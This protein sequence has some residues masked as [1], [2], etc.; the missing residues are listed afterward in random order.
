MENRPHETDAHSFARKDFAVIGF[1]TS[2][3]ILTVVLFFVPGFVVSF[4]GRWHQFFYWIPFIMGTPIFSI[5][6]PVYSMWKMDE[7]GWGTSRETENKKQSPEEIALVSANA[8]ET[9]LQI[10]ESLEDE[11][12]GD[13]RLLPETGPN[14]L[15]FSSRAMSPTPDAVALAALEY[16]RAAARLARLTGEVPAVSFEDQGDYSTGADSV[17]GM[18]PAPPLP[19]LLASEYQQGQ[20]EHDRQ[21]LADAYERALARL[22]SLPHTAH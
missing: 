9:S 2:G 5:L 11:I 10:A 6:I 16:E 20:S 12:P 14:G 4:T 18:E 21:Q 3:L 8:E 13:G 1:G 17:Y 7:F 22:A 15:A 19:Q